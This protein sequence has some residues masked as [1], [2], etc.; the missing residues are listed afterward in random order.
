VPSGIR[1]QCFK[2]HRLCEICELW[3]IIYMTSSMI[4]F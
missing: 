4:T 3:D 1:W 2:A